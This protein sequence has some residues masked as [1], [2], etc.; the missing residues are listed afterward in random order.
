MT[1]DN[2]LVTSVEWR[3][4][5]AHWNIPALTKNQKMGTVSLAPFI[6]FGWGGNRKSDQPDPRSISSIGLG[7]RW[8]IS[9]HLYSEIYWGL[10][11][12]DIDQT[13]SDLQ[14][15]GIHF[16]ISANVFD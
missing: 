9:E 13:D 6:D 4:P 3:I 2:G 10:A 1:P 16:L 14:D 15:N 8:T 11:L 5:V 12:R 7:A